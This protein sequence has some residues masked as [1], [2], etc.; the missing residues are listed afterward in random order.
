MEH[1]YE[2]QFW[3]NKYSFGVHEKFLKKKKNVW[4]PY[5]FILLYDCVVP[6]F[7]QFV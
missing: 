6:L 1:C 4:S 3:S 2:T 5:L 7:I